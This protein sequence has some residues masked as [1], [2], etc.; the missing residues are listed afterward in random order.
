MIEGSRTT[1]PYHAESTL[2]SQCKLQQRAQ[3]RVQQPTGL[4]SKIS[5]LDSQV[6]ACSLSGTCSAPTQ[7]RPQQIKKPHAVRHSGS[8]LS[9][10]PQDSARAK[11]SSSCTGDPRPRL[12]S[13]RGEAT[14]RCR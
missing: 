4:V 10:Q 8:A 9:R 2:S 11:T 6:L 12:A 13:P 14:A 3:Q 7:K 1:F 5:A